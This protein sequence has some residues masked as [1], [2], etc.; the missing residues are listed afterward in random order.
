LVSQR[1]KV[2]R[3]R[4]AFLPIG[5]IKNEKACCFFSHPEA[6]LTKKE[7]KIAMQ[8]PLQHADKRSKK[9][10]QEWQRECTIHSSTTSRANK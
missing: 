7:E 6:L 4:L 9:Q 3:D 2:F 5:F 1:R 8:S 10:A